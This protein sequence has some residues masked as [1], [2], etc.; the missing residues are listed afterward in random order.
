MA[1]GT[2][3]HDALRTNSR[4]AKVDIMQLGARQPRHALFRSIRLSRM[5]YAVTVG[6]S[7]RA[8]AMKVF[9]DAVKKKRG[10]VFLVNE[11]NLVPRTCFYISILRMTEYSVLIMIKTIDYYF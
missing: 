3:A 11:V 5:R 1:P 6:D 8:I 7:H 2:T 9:S 4:P 10:R